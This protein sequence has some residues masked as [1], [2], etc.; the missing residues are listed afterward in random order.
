MLFSILVLCVSYAIRAIKLFD[1]SSRFVRLNLRTRP[2]NAIK[3]YLHSLYIGL[4]NTSTHGW[5]LSIPYYVIL[6]TLLVIRS[7]LD[8]LDSMLWEVRK[9]LQQK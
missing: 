7:W 8:L 9:V 3:Q 1:Q 2:G 6:S 4:Q 5:I